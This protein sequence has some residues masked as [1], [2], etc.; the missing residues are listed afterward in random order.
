MRPAVTATSAV[1]R[2]SPGVARR[3]R[4]NSSPAAQRVTAQTRVNTI[5]VGT[6]AIPASRIAIGL[7]GQS[8]PQARL[9]MVVGITGEVRLRI[10]QPA[11]VTTSAA[12]TTATDA[13]PTR[14]PLGK[15]R[16]T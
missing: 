15:A 8:A 2:R 4:R 11:P 10:S 12:P 1:A 9:G 5:R 7:P 3:T 16:N 6:S 13:R 14:R